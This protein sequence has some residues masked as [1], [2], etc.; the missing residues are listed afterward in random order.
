MIDIDYEREE[1]TGIPEV[2][3]CEYK[4]VEQIRNAALRIMERKPSVF[5]TR[6]DP[7]K[8]STLANSL[9]GFEYNA[10]GRYFSAGF[11][12]SHLRKGRPLVLSAGTSDEPVAE[13]CRGTLRFLGYNVDS[14]GDC[15]VA[16]LHRLLKHQ[17]SIISADVIIVVAG[18]EGALP[19]VV[20]GLTRAPVIGVPT[21]VGYGAGFQGKTALYSMLTACSGG[22]GVM[23]IDNGFGAALY[24]AKILN[25]T[26]K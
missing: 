7:A 6:L 15:G 11:P 22:I 20:A 13:E 26:G 23:N 21:S 14:A 16:G 12:E 8:A 25:L 24:A 4:S 1:R 10:V 9:E 18:M 5:G 17:D 3:Y 2:I 19:G